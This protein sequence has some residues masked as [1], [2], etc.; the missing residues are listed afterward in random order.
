[1]QKS[2]KFSIIILIMVVL[3]V[4]A[5]VLIANFNNNDRVIRMYNNLSNADRFT[6]SMEEVNSEIKYK[7]EISQ[8][9]KDVNIDMD[10][11]GERT[12]T[13]ILNDHAYYISHSEKQYY[14]YNGEN[15][16]GDIILSGLKEAVGKEY[17]TGKEYIEGKEYY[18]EEYSNITS[19]L[20]LLDDYDEEVVK[21]R[22]YFDGDNIVYIKNIAK[23]NGKIDDE[24]LKT[25]LKYEADDSLFEIPE[26]YSEMEF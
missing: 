11:D 7:M 6:F 22:F 21:T 5:G 10:S 2:K 3:C 18:Y 1:M 17:T 9:G 13:L 16:D 15:I 25:N 14:D 20:I 23:I 24:I 26:D 4:I 19:F 8:R 12:S